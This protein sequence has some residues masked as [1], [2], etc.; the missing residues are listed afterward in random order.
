MR[1]EAGFVVDPDEVRRLVDGRTRLLFVNSPHNPTGAVL[2]DAELDALHGVASAAGATLVSDEV[3]HPLAF[4]EPPRSAARFP[5]AIVLGDCSKAL[6]LSGLRVGWIV[7]RDPARRSRHLDAR[8]YFTISNSPLTEALAAIAI[9]HRDHI[10]RRALDAVAA[11]LG[12]F[13]AFLE[14][15]AEIEWVPPAGSTTAFPWLRGSADARPLCSVL[16]ERGVLLAPGDC[17][18]MP[19]HFRIGFGGPPEAFAAGL[20]ELDRALAREEAARR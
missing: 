6:S 9:R 8:G 14:E 10:L 5:D 19:A 12:R 13:R 2:G 11:N 20:Q 7:D 3:Y 1:R 18:G 17:F 4:G 15:H 16:A